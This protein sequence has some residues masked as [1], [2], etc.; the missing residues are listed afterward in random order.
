[1]ITNF[2]SILVDN[3]QNL[4]T[5]RPNIDYSIIT[6]FNGEIDIKDVAI[7]VK[8]NSID[9][10][11]DIPQLPIIETIITV[12][13]P[14]NK[15]LDGTFVRLIAND[16]IEAMNEL[17]IIDANFKVDGCRFNGFKNTDD[18]TAKA[19]ELTYVFNLTLGQG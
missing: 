2:D 11:D 12:V 5:R 19:I 9:N 7:V 15:D 14:I 17:S 13:V 4:I 3:L 18:D 1:M 8:I 6:H 16:V 10:E